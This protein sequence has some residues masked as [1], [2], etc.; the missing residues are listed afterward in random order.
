M[1][2]GVHACLVVVSPSGKRELGTPI[3]VRRVFAAE[4]TPQPEPPGPPP[5]QRRLCLHCPD[6]R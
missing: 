6:G 2:A 1:K 4:L 5:L 3:S